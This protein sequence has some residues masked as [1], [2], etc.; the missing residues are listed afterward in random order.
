MS[1]LNKTLL[2]QTPE[3]LHATQ[4]PEEAPVQPDLKVPEPHAAHATQLPGLVPAHPTL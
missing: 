1:N 2:I 4:D 3:A